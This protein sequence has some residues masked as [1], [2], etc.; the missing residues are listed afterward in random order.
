MKSRLAKLFDEI[1]REV[2]ENPRL[3]ERLDSVL[4]ESAPNPE[5]KVV[6]RNKRQPG[7]LDPYVEFSLSEDNLREKLN[8]LTLEQLKDVISEG[9]IDSSRLAL[10]WQKRERLVNLIVDTVRSRSE[11]GDVFRE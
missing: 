3:G 8:A 11:K 4:A 1:L 5:H 2:A 7:E 6:R 10:K 9:A